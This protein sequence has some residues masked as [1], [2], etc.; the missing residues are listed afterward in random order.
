MRQTDS[1]P[2]KMIKPMPIQAKVVSRASPSMPMKALK[3]IVV[4]CNAAVNRAE[5]CQARVMVNCP[6]RP[7][8][9]PNSAR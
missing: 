1:N 7:V 8:P 4:Y 2:A 9:T 5:P 3:M 6:T